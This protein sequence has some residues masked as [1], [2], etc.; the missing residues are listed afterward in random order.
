MPLTMIIDS[1]ASTCG[2]CGRKAGILR[3]NHQDYEETHQAGRQE[4]VSLVAQAATD[5]SFN[6]AALRQSLSGIA[7]RYYAGDEDIERA[8]EE[9]WKQGVGNAMSDGIITREG[10]ERL[11]AFRDSLTLE[12][13]DA[14]QGALAD[15]DRASANRIMLEAR[16]AAISV[17]D[18][19]SHL[20]NLDNTLRQAGLGRDEARRLLN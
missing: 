10:E 1:L 14:D 2:Y 19:D 5:H 15:L 4:M 20:R 3:R 6:E 17:Q 7:Q 12:D 13:R 9:G 11:R 16:L 8:L 18:G